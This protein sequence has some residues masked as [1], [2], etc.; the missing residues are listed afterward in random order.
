[1]TFSSVQTKPP[2]IPNREQMSRKSQRSRKIKVNCVVIGF[3]VNVL[4]KKS[5]SVFK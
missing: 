5:C 2:C 3:T 1:M 4:V